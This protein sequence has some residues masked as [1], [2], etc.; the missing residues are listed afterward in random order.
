LFETTA[1]VVVKLPEAIG[2]DE[3][4]VAA[5]AELSETIGIDVVWKGYADLKCCN[6]QLT[7]IDEAYATFEM[8]VPFS[9]DGLYGSAAPQQK[10]QLLGQ[11]MGLR[12]SQS[13]S[14]IYNLLYLTDI[15]ALSVMYHIEGKAYLSKRVTDAKAFCMRLL[16]MCHNFSPDE[17]DTLILAGASAVDI[18]MVDCNVSPINSNRFN[19]RAHGRTG[20]VTRSEKNSD[21]NENAHRAIYGTI[22][23]EEEE[24]QERRQADIADVLRWEAKCL[25]YKYLGDQEMK[26]HNS[27]VS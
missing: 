23:C 2:P 7:G 14:S 15:F 17:W 3:V 11:A 19:T 24:A 6:S 21:G 22:G 12:Q 9:K 18:H 5:V 16:L 4:A 25:G 10:Q 13:A 26:Q 20:P 8:K 1:G 27:I